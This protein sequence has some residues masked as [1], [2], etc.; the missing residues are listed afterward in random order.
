MRAETNPFTFVATA[1]GTNG[2]IPGYFMIEYHYVFKNAIGSSWEFVADWKTNLSDNYSQEYVSAIPLLE[3]ENLNP[4]QILHFREG[5]WEYEDGS[6]VPTN[7]YSA[8]PAAVLACTPSTPVRTLAP[9]GQEN[10]WASNTYLAAIV[11]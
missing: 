7:N 5:V 8:I 2:V 9:S 1:Q 11:T 10:P 3:D 4:A 6:P